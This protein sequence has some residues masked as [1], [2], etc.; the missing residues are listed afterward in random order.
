MAENVQNK[1]IELLFIIETKICYKIYIYQ[2]RLLQT[3]VP[4][5]GYKLKIITFIFAFPNISLNYIKLQ[6]ESKIVMT[7]YPTRLYKLN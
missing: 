2:I 6:F 7:V 1:N 3:I 5:H 4:K